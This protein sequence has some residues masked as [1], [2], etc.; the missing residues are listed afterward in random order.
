MNE[1][2]LKLLMKMAGETVGAPVQTDELI[3]I[4]SVMVSAIKDL[5]SQ[6]E[7]KIGDVSSETETLSKK[8]SYALNDIEYTLKGITN[9]S[10]KNNLEKIKEISQRLS[11]EIKRVEEMIPSSID[12]TYLEQ[13]IQEVE[14]KI[15]P[16]PVMPE[17]PVETGSSI[18]DKINALDP[19][20]NE[21][22]IGVDHIKGLVNELDDLRFRISNSSGS[23]GGIGGGGVSQVYHDDTLSGAGTQ[24]SP[25]TVVGGGSGAAGYQAPTGTVNGSNAVFVFA[26][27]PNAVSVDGVCLRKT[28]SDTTVNWTGTTTITLTVAPNFDIFGLN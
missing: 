21:D 2:Q 23:R 14:S 15:Q 7:N 1:K 16:V 25:L 8:V 28:A 18:V 24:A 5:K 13:K 9:S 22:K 17:I 19:N 3:Q 6:L 27:A 11:N 20:V 26:T 10:D 12:L 4:I